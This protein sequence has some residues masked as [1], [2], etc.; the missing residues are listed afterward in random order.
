VLTG[1]RPCWPGTRKL[2]SLRFSELMRPSLVSA[3][4]GAAGWL[5]RRKHQEGGGSNRWVGGQAGGGCAV[6][7]AAP[8]LRALLELV[9]SSRRL[10]VMVQ[11][12]LRR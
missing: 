6:P 4:R 3:K 9:T 2:G 7:A 10:P 8:G 1:R 5:R 12:F 11:A